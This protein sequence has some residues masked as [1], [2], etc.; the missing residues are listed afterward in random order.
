MIRAT[1]G[2]AFALLYLLSNYYIKA[3]EAPK[4]IIV[5]EEEIENNLDIESNGVIET[6]NEDTNNVF[7]DENSEQKNLIVIDDIPKEF[8]QWYGVLSSEQGGLG[9]LKW[10][11]T[12]QEYAIK[13]MRTSMLL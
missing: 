2:I 5:I 7:S 3:E 4:N 9:W 1:Y 13:L 11:N 10:G 8:N 6:D 12:P